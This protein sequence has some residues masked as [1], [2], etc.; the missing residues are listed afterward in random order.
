MNDIKKVFI[1]Y[2]GPCTERNLDITRLER[3]FRINN[4]IIVKNIK[5][6]DYIVFVTCAFVDEKIKTSMDFIRECRNYDAEL[7]VLGCLP[8]IAPDTLR[9]RL[10]RAGFRK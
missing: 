8:G 6:A 3:Y 4:C 10:S 2:T 7:I 5:K 1:A 9:N